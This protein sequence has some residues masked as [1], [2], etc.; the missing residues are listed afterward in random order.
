MQ[1]LSLEYL[2][3]SHI[4]H[5]MAYRPTDDPMLRMLDAE[6]YENYKLDSAVNQSINQSINHLHTPCFRCAMYAERCV[7]YY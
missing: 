3:M 5:H 1:S 6:A 2:N 7:F 4:I